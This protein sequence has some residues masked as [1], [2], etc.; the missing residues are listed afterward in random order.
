MS[1]PTGPI[2]NGTSTDVSVPATTAA[3]FGVL[4]GA[5]LYGL[6]VSGGVA[7]VIGLVIFFA[8]IIIVSVKTL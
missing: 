2:I 7:A 6:G 3:I 5:I 8:G 1:K 4:A